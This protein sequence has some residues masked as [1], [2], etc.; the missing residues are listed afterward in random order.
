MS[1]STLEVAATKAISY[2]LY[3]GTFIHTPKLG[4]LEIHINAL[5]GVDPSGTIDYI[6]TQYTGASGPAA[7][8]AFHS[9]YK[10]HGAL[11]SDS[12]RYVDISDTPTKFFCPG[13]VDT[14][15]H[16]SQYPNVG[17]GLD[18]Q[19]LD[20]LKDYTYELEN[21]FVDNKDK[22][23]HAGDVYGKLIRKTLQSGTTCASYFT[24]IDPET[25]RLFAELLLDIGQRG[26]VGKV[27]MD[28]NDVY[29]AYKEDHDTCLRT[30]DQIVDYCEKINPDDE[31]LV[32]AIVTPRFAPT[33]SRSLL[34]ELGS[35]A[36]SKKLPIQTHLSENRNEIDLVLECFPEAHSYTS[37]YDKFGLLTPSTILAHGV[38]LDEDECKLI[39][40]KGSS[41]S[42]C[43]TSNTFLSSGEAP[44]KKYLY[45]DQINISLGTDVS[46]GYNLSILEIVKQSILVSHHRSMKTEK[47]EFDPKLSISDALYMATQAGAKAVGLES[48]IGSFEEGKRWDAQLIDLNSK[49]SN[50][51]V[52]PCNL[53]DLK[54]SDAN[55]TQIKIKNLLGKWIFCGDDRNCV[56]VWCN[57]RLVLDKLNFD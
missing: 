6:N 33:C 37:V 9:D 28:Q 48:V 30:M 26:F 50:V 3:Q 32:Q 43:P 17:I 12:I 25:T 49:T 29:P 15:I 5:I 7:I 55:G 47:T 39:K 1:T 19:L 31:Y 24:T 16:A 40:S 36:A 21:S 14:H 11:E 18:C 52:F 56:Q 42:H 20:W 45:K 38:Y 13:F 46:G 4:S 53:P 51:D 34:Q 22:L 23:A 8:K 54:G 27:C 2:T 10:G 44:V 35:L 57:G 41:I